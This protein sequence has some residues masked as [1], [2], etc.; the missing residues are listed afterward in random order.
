MSRV[1][2][3]EQPAAES[4][5]GSYYELFQSAIDTPTS[6]SQVFLFADIV[7]STEMKEQG[8]I[9]WLPTVGRFY[10]VVE[11]SVET[12]GGTIV[13]Y[14]GDGAIARFSDERAAEAINTAI[15]I[16]EQLDDLRFR[17]V[18][19]CRCSI[20]LTTGKGIEFAVN[21]RVD[22][23]G[24][25]V[26]LSARLTTA[27]AANAIW[28]DANTISAANMAR[29]NSEIGR[30]HKRE[31][32]GYITPEEKINLKG[33]PDAVRYHEVIWSAGPY[34]VR[35]SIVTQ[36]VESDIAKKT[37]EVRP[38]PVRSKDDRRNWQTG[39]VVTWSD[40]KRF[41][42]IRGTG[43][44]EDRYVQAA[45][46]V[47]ND[48]LRKGDDV[49]FIP[50]PAHVPGRNNIAV[51]V[52]PL[53]RAVESKVDVVPAGKSY[54]FVEVTD[55]AKTQNS[56]LIY[57]EVS[58]GDRNVGTWLTVTVSQDHTGKPVARAGI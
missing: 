57:A 43:E 3:T 1:T 9:T 35:N 30:A 28:A 49:A 11:S 42:F 50:R 41:G 51:C 56:G 34:G 55:S 23:I 13:K 46:L 45:W 38:T 25:V 19:Q 27:A 18:S 37:S 54:V 22:F 2:S 48:G 12:T 8:E 31:P 7:G 6:G 5:A 17:K 36:I 10:D 33:F 40:D 32:S 15:A 44:A 21:G 53:G 14:L 52:T 47:V 58:D 29:V 26:D 20:A 4:P 24:S 39:R 16:Q